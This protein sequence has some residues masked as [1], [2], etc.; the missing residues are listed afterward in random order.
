MLRHK[1]FALSAAAALLFASAPAWATG[2]S[3]NEAPLA[4]GTTLDQCKA[5][6]KKAISE[7]GLKAV[8]ES[9]LSVFGMADPDILAAIYCL[10]E[11]GIAVV[12]VAGTDNQFTR[13][14]LAK[15]LAGMGVK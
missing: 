4:A 9:P 12:A 6:G 3:M 11:R 7:A 8:P 13:P 15:L 1:K 2:L 5:A 14:V 10:P